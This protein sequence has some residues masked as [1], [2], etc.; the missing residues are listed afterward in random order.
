VVVDSRC[1]LETAEKHRGILR[2]YPGNDIMLLH[3]TGKNG[4]LLAFV[5]SLLKHC[6]L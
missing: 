3:V 2:K 5:F 6:C 4:T 1:I